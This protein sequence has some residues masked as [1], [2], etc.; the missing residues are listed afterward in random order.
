M[1]SLD[2]QRSSKYMWF[3]SFGE[4]VDTREQWKDS[5]SHPIAWQVT[6]QSYL[7]HQVKD[8]KEEKKNKKE[9]KK[10]TIYLISFFY[11]FSFTV[12][13]YFI[14]SKNSVILHLLNKDHYILIC[15]TSST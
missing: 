2:C 13:L 7:P 4:L 8:R 1:A 15:I 5:C 14:N 3:I 9:N 10:E 12:Y 11:L 6:K